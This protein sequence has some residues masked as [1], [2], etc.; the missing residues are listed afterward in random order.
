MKYAIIGG[1]I[2]GLACAYFLCKKKHQIKLFEKTNQLGGLARTTLINGKP[3]EVYYHH[4]NKNHTHLFN[5]CKELGV[6][7]STFKAGMGFLSNGIIYDFDNLLDLWNFK[8]LRLR[9]KVSFGM[10]YF[11]TLDGNKQVYET[12][13]K[14][15]LIHKF[16]IHYK[17]ISI[18]YIWSRPK[19]NGK[20]YYI[21]TQSLI[22]ALKLNILAMGGEIFMEKEK[23]TDTYNAVIDTTPCNKDMLEV[24]CLLLVMDRPLTKY[25]WLNIGDLDFPF[26][27][28]VQKGNILYITKYGKTEQSF[29]SHL[30]RINPDFKPEWIKQ[31]FTFHDDYAQ[32]AIPTTESRG[33][34]NIIIKAWKTSL[35]C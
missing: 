17:D 12:I 5:L 10:S 13:W 8:P 35:S 26:G 23:D 28:L 11:F 2:G 1:G 30:N 9:D 19:C 6:S 34:N 18:Q 7:I 4:Y 20:L 24:T 32:E 25:Y 27:H 33:L 3:V 21:S 22:D 14:P 29:T 16:G 31:V 15:L